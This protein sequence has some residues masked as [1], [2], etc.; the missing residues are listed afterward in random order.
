MTRR[1]EL[2]AVSTVE[3]VYE[4][5]RDFIPFMERLEQRY[6]EPGMVKVMNFF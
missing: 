4:E 2:E 1:F 3:P 6:Y 5:F